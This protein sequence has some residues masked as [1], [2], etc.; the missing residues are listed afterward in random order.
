MNKLID[1][2]VY[3]FG[4]LIFGK[5]IETDKSLIGR[6]V[7]YKDDNIIIASVSCC[8]VNIFPDSKYVEF[9]VHG[10]TDYNKHEY[11]DKNVF[12]VDVYSEKNAKEIRDI[13]IKAI[14]TVNNGRCEK[15]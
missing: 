8:E 12:M 7:L 5:I 1:A 15:V 2:E 9:Y 13:I 11:K 14:E 4:N 3:Y 10:N 6:G